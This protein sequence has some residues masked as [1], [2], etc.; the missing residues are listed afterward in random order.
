MQGEISDESGPDYGDEEE[1]KHYKINDIQ[2]L[3]KIG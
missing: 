3:E 2:L 1:Y